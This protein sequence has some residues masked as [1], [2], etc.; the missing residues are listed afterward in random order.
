VSVARAIAVATVLLASLYIVFFVVVG[1]GLG[2]LFFGAFSPVATVGGL[3]ALGSV[4]GAAAC[5]GQRWCRVA[6]AL[7]SLIAIAC[8]GLEALVYY[9]Y[10]NIPGNYFGWPMR[11][12]F[13]VCLAIIGA[14]NLIAQYHRPNTSL[15]RTREG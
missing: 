5:A 12:P 14:A 10:H 11:V 3:S 2:Q 13:V 1:Y 15:E 9:K 6:L 4:F 7:L 8:V